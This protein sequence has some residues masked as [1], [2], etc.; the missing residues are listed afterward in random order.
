[1]LVSRVYAYI[2]G[3]DNN[4]H[5]LLTAF[6]ALTIATRTILGRNMNPED[7]IRNCKVEFLSIAS[8]II[9]RLKQKNLE[10]DLTPKN[11]RTLS[12]IIVTLKKVS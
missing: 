5:M 3:L 7:P 10:K 11:P 12:A 6:D 8:T 2:L 4:G 9:L 1:M